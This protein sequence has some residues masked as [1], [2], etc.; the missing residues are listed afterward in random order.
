MLASTMLSYWLFVYFGGAYMFIYVFFIVPL[1]FRLLAICL[2]HW[3]SC[4]KTA[5]NHAHHKHLSVSRT[6]CYCSDWLAEDKAKAIADEKRRIEEEEAN[7]LVGPELPA[8]VS[9]QD[10]GDYG[11]ALLPGKPLNEAITIIASLCCF[12]SFS[13]VC[14]ASSFVQDHAHAAAAAVVIVVA[15]LGLHVVD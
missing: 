6:C 13:W 10:M 9:Q 2:G 14:L 3:Q 8:G 4:A 11:G 12:H 5:A 1:C 7:M 15:S